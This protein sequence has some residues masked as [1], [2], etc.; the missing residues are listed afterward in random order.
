[1]NIDNLNQ[2]ILQMTPVKLFEF[3]KNIRRKRREGVIEKERKKAVKGKGKGST[4]KLI[5]KL[6]PEQT[7]QL[8]KIL[9]GL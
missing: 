7:Q 3:F 5:E 2:S 8:L 4:E 1:M 9:K 6:S